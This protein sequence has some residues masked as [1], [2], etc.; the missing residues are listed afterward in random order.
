MFKDFEINRFKTNVPLHLQ[1]LDAPKFVKGDYTTRLIG[2]D[3]NYKERT[4]DAEEARMAMI[5]I[6][7]SAYNKEFKGG[8]FLDEENSR[9]KTLGREEGL[10]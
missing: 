7:V 5:A 1:L 9:W 8:K 2:D 4:P 6:A 10:R 3:F